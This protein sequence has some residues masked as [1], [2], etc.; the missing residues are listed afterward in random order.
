MF[1]S[2]FKGFKTKIYALIGVIFIG[3]LAA[4]KWKNS[5]IKEKEEKI[6]ELKN[7]IKVSKKLADENMKVKEFNAR[8]E[9]KKEQIDADIK[10]HN[11]KVEKDVKD[12]TPSNRTITI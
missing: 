6:V 3:L 7:H 9:L 1:N 10:E 2:L 8:Q 4:L 5:S 12:T 11:K